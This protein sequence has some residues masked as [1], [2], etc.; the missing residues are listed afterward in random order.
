MIFIILCC[1]PPSIFV[2][3]LS[4]GH[5]ELL[6]LL[7]SSDHCW[8]LVWAIAPYLERSCDQLRRVRPSGIVRTWN[9]T[10]VL[11]AQPSRKSTSVGRSVGTR[12]YCSSLLFPNYV[13][14]INLRSCVSLPFNFAILIIEPIVIRHMSAVTYFHFSLKSSYFPCRGL[15]ACHTN[16]QYKAMHT[17]FTTGEQPVLRFIALDSEWKKRRWLT[18]PKP[19][20][21][22]SLQYFPRSLNTWLL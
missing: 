10:W 21:I 22:R 12:L 6:Q 9:S 8:L 18:V 15:E 3:D 20:Q 11:G 1:I 4:N 13:R 16:V 5:W 17:R 14:I 7:F 2:P 19:V